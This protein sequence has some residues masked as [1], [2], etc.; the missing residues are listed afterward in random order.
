MIRKVI[1]NVLGH[2]FFREER[3][4]GSNIKKVPMLTC[5]RCFQSFLYQPEDPTK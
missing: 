5:K 4:Y 2:R 3:W 1:C